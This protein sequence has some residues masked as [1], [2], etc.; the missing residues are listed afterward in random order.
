MPLDINEVRL[1]FSQGS[2]DCFFVE[3]GFVWYGFVGRGSCIFLG[4]SKVRARRTLS[5]VTQ[6]KASSYH[7]LLYLFNKDQE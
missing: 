3:G 1:L 7:I 2:R 4:S 6:Q 5:L